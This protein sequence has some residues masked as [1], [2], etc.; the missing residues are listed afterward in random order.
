MYRPAVDVIIN[1]SLDE[2]FVACTV[3]YLRSLSCVNGE[4]RSKIIN[5]LNNNPSLL[6]RLESAISH[7]D[8]DQFEVVLEDER[9]RRVLLKLAVGHI[10][11]ECNEVMTDEPEYLNYKILPELPGESVSEFDKNYIVDILPE[12]G[13]PL[14]QKI[15]EL[16]DGSIYYPWFMVQ[17]GQYRYMIICNEGILIRIVIGEYLFAEIKWE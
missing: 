2:S 5:Y 3:E 14:F 17:D 6:Q 4:M 7:K 9:I 12:L 1:F 11:Y 16:S 13:S 10:A 8:N 15:V